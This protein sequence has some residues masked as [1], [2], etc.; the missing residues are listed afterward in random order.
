[1]KNIVTIGSIVLGLLF[2]I[3]AGMYVLTPAGS[4]PTF[5][6]GFQAGSLTIHYKHAIGSCIVGLALFVYAWFTSAP[7]KAN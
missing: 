3:V 7:A 6:P 2:I 1:M 4:L 5:M